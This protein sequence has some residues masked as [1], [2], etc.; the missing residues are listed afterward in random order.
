MRFP[1]KVYKDGKFWLAEIPIL[2]AMTQ[3]HTRKEAL[4]MVA[5]MVETMAN[6]EGFR[7]EVVLGSGGNF[8][9][10]SKDLKPLI[11]LLLQ[12]KRELSN[13]SLAQA[14]E[15]LGASSRNAYA[16]YEQGRSV[17]TIGKLNELLNAVSPNTDLVIS[18]SQM[19]WP[20]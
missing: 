4:K 12:R 5:D 16:R 19:A 6:K 3:G 18:E 2:E 1:G 8:E 9:V 7:A 10:G 14:A 17:P 11:I 13:L 20:E 15:R